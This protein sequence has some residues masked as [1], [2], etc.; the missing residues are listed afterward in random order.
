MA[1]VIL[2]DNSLVGMFAPMSNTSRSCRQT[3]DKHAAGTHLAKAD[4]AFTST[5]RLDDDIT[6]FLSVFRKEVVRETTCRVIY[7]Q[8]VGMEACEVGTLRYRAFGPEQAVEIHSMTKTR[9]DF[10]QRE[11]LQGTSIWNTAEGE[12]Q[13]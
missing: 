8:I 11:S 12:T 1:A 9:F 7:D 3:L 6:L 4:H 5:H 13:R 2:P 10:S